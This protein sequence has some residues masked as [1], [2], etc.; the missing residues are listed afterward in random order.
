MM[1]RAAH[2]AAAAFALVVGLSSANA[3][4]VNWVLSSPHN[5]DPGTTE[6]FSATVGLNTYTLGAAGYRYSGAITSNSFTAI[7]LYNKFTSGDA[8]ESGLGIKNDPTGNHE[9]YTNTFVR[10]DVTTARSQGLGNFS[11]KFGSTTQGE[12]WEVFGSTAANTGL[13][14]L[15][16]QHINDQSNTYSLPDVNGSNQAYDFFYFVY[17]G[18][19]LTKD[20][21][22]HVTSTCG[23][24]NVLLTAF[25][26]D[27][28]TTTRQGGD[29]PLP[30]ALPMFAG[31]LGVIGLLARRRMRKAS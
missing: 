27:I 16:G 28:L 7:D 20:I 18:P 2:L 30:A 11:F 5:T 4:T 22:G 12:G 31:G 1:F 13:T 9:I 8:T 10:L 6:T 25:G 29:T 14:L 23:G 21:W 15:V 24:C 19:A 26:G 17:D 3:A